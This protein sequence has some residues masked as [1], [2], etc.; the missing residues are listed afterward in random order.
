MSK[1]GMITIFILLGV[2]LLLSAFLLMTT[3]IEVNNSPVIM[4]P[5]TLLIKEQIEDTISECMEKEIVTAA[6]LIGER[7]GYYHIEG[8]FFMD[9]GHIP[10]YLSDKQKKIPKLTEV[11]NNIDL[12]L[13]EMINNCYKQVREINGLSIN[14]T[15][16]TRITNNAIISRVDT[17][18][19]IIAGNN[20]HISLKP[21]DIIVNDIPIYRVYAAI[22]EYMAIAQTNNICVDCLE[23][24]GIKYNVAFILHTYE[25][26]TVY[27]VEDTYFKKEIPYT[28]T[29]ANKIINYDCDY[30]SPDADIF[31]YESCIIKKL[32]KDRISEVLPDQ[33]GYVNESFTIKIKSSPE[34]INFTEHLG[35]FDIDQE[36]GIMTYTPTKAGEIPILIRVEKLD[37]AIIYRSFTLVIYDE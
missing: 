8:D 6:Y 28:W 12:I 5:E 14:A 13:N 30:P 25:D 1:K 9:D 20:V 37:N 31:F 10:Y 36:K 24:I 22:Y 7:G 27:I 33:F 11:E 4:I 34:E 35:I 32:E 18:T 15:I 21:F 2:I 16:N 23:R 3:Q 29:F 26:A 17:T 19:D